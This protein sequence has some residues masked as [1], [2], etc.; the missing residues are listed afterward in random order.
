MKEH[1]MFA[2]KVAAVLFVINQIPQIGK[3]INTNYFAKA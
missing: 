3:I 1:L 2:A